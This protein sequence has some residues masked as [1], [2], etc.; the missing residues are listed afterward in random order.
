M[1]FYFGLLYDLA[2]QCYREMYLVILCV[3]VMSVGTTARVHVHHSHTR[4]VLP[5]ARNHFILSIADIV[6]HAMMNFKQ[7]RHRHLL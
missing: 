6:G 4:I 2:K 7:N 1:F 5:A 3:P